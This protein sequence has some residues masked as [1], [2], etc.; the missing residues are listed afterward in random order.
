MCWNIKFKTAHTTQCLHSVSTGSSPSASIKPHP[1]WHSCAK[2]RSVAGFN[3]P[4]LSLHPGPPS[5]SPRTGDFN[6][7]TKAQDYRI[8][9]SLAHHDQRSNISA[10]WTRWTRWRCRL[11]YANQ[12]FLRRSSLKGGDDNMCDFPLIVPFQK[13]TRWELVS[14]PV[15]LSTSAV[16]GETKLS[17]L[18]RRKQSIMGSHHALDL[19]DWWPGSKAIMN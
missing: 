2:S 14:H 1:Q 16:C 7:A 8:S 19:A 3:P 6:P 11:V 5:P 17:A 12:A 13:V 18:F 4:R 15:W 9:P 10:R